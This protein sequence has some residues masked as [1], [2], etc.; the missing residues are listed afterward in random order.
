MVRVLVVL[1]VLL[2]SASQSIAIDF[3][4]MALGILAMHLR[5]TPAPPIVPIPAPS[6]VCENCDGKGKVGDGRVFVECPVCEG[7][8][9]SK[10]EVAPV[11]SPKVQ[12]SCAD[13]S[14]APPRRRGLLG[15]WLP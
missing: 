15:R 4:G 2:G 7:T 14:C 13:G 1:V 9:K 5:P 8:G 12:E 3:K 10:T 6:G 11:E